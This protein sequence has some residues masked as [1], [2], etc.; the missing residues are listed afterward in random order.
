MTGGEASR[1]FEAKN[2]KKKEQSKTTNAPYVPSYLVQ[3]YNDV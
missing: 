2:K 3:K 1:I